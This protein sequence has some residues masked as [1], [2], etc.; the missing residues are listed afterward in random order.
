[1]MLP[2]LSRTLGLIWIE[3]SCRVIER[4]GVLITYTCSCDAFLIGQ[5]GVD[6][7]RSDEWSSKYSQEKER[8]SVK[9]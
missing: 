5:K 9:Q 2:F 8:I 4:G 6:I 1:M 3:D 7:G